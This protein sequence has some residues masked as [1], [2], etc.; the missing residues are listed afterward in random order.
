M[1][2]LDEWNH[3]SELCRNVMV[4]Y[5]QSIDPLTGIDRRTFCSPS[6]VL[7]SGTSRKICS[8]QPIL[9]MASIWNIVVVVGC[10]NVK[11]RQRWM[12]G[13]WIHGVARML[14][15][16]KLQCERSEVDCVP[17]ATWHDIPYD[18]GKLNGE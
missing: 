5:S 12:Q 8:S 14:V 13:M 11:G 7:W 17:L 4:L 2:R 3:R 9:T 16:G 10:L 6:S 1:Q 18:E 15:E